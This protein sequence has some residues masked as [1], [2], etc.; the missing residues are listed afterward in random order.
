MLRWQH[1]CP[2]FCQEHPSA[3]MAMPTNQYFPMLMKP[4]IDQM[5]A[6]GAPPPAVHAAALPLFLLADPGSFL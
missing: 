3:Y 1:S 5:L 6:G 4:D 2:R